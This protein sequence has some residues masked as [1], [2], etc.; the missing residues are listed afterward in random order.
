MPKGIG[1]RRARWAANMTQVELSQKSGVEQ[2]VISM[3][4]TGK[5]DISNCSFFTVYNLA[6][7]L[8]VPIDA[9]IEQRSIDRMMVHRLR[10][11]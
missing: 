7:A 3:V 8:G 2:G 9:L 10:K 6:N 1:L 4:E 5:M 11:K